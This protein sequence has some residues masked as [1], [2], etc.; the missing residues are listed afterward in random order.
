MS[1]S[2]YQGERVSVLCVECGRAFTSVR[3]GA[4][5]CGGKCKQVAYNE[6]R[7]AWK[8][9]AGDAASAGGVGGEEEGTDQK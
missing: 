2:S 5:Y 6:R 3:P 7:R 4:L 1:E 9:A 8:A